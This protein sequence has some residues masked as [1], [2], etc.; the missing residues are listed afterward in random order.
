MKKVRWIIQNN[1]IAEND[2]KQLQKVL[3]DNDIEFFEVQ[4]IPFMSGLPAFPIDDEHE[5]IYYGSTTFMN[6]IYKELN[7]I[8]L[9]YDHTTFSM[10]NYLNKW[11]HDMLS[12]AGH[13][14]TTLGEFSNRNYNKNQKWFIRP[15]ADSKSFNGEVRTFEEIQNLHKN[16]TVSDDIE[17]NSSTEIMVAKPW[18]IKAEWRNYVVNGEIVSSTLYRKNF[19][20][21]KSSKYIPPKMIELTKNYIS[22]YQP[23][24]VFCIDIGYCGDEI[25]QIIE[26]GCMNSCGWYAADM[27][28]IV[29][30][31]SKYVS[32]ID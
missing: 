28:K 21:N 14:C 1:L 30:A 20:L 6:N 4:I 3:K 12:Y 8:G 7:P 11:K 10:K 27:N 24:D 13:H 32:N 23:H 25:Y 22:K 9:F 17:L 2:L 29:L 31:V 18:N 5:N 15:D 16:I 26:C 19:K